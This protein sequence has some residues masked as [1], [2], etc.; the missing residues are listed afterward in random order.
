MRESYKPAIKLGVTGGIGGGKTTVCRVFSVL[1]I[2]VFSADIEARKIMNSDRNLREKI[3]S[4]SGK[5]LYSSGSLDREELAKLIFNNEK[6]LENVNKLV[7][8]AVFESF[9]K[10]SADLSAPY[11]IMEAAILFES[12][13]SMLV[14]KV[15]TVVTPAEERIERL[16]RGKKFTRDQVIERMKNQVNDDYRIRKSDF[17]IYN[18]ENDMIIPAIL[19]IHQELLNLYNRTG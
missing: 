11:A 18:S 7:H 14:D 5:D 9:R 13:A 15:L 10:W 19:E 3:S 4:I 12:G 8:P 1:G 6:L 17:I 16:V 2:P